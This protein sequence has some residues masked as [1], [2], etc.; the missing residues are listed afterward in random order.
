MIIMK[1][2]KKIFELAK[3][4]AKETFASTEHDRMLSIRLT[5]DD[6]SY[7]LFYCMGTAYIGS[8]ANEALP[9]FFKTRDIYEL[10]DDTTLEVEA[11]MQKLIRI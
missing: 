1:P 3:A 11:R 2:S 5:A 8:Y 10:T 9:K 6:K 7:T 4:K